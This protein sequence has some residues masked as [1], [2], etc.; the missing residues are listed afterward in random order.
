MTNSNTTTIPT[1]AEQTEIA[2]RAHAVVGTRVTVAGRTYRVSRFGCEL[3]FHGEEKYRG[4]NPAGAI[5]ACLRTDLAVGGCFA[6]GF[7]DLALEAACAA[8]V[9]AA[10]AS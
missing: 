5:V 8:V 1:Y 9:T 10:L 3:R 6:G 4:E 2:I 7:R